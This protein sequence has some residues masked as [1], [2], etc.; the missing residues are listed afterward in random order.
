MKNEDVRMIN[1]VIEPNWLVLVL[2][3]MA[4]G[5]IVEGIIISRLLQQQ[6]FQKKE[7]IED[8]I[9]RF[10]Y[11]W[12]EFVAYVLATS[13]VGIFIASLVNKDNITLADINSWVSIILGFVALIVG[14]ISLY[15]S[16]YNVEQAN[17]SQQEIKKTAEELSVTRG[18][19][20]DINGEWYFG[21]FSGKP[22]R[23]E[24]KKSGDNW[25]Y[26]DSDG[27]VA[28]DTIINDGGD[29]YYVDKNGVMV[30]NTWVVADEKKYYMTGNGKAVL[31]GTKTIDGKEYTFENGYLKE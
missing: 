21:D 3:A 6:K 2:S 22:V 12:G 29:I 27:M 28:K 4:I 7:G 11:F 15:L 19:Q 16:F 20:K 5:I 8:K 14:I 1:I 13:I 9:E 31:S 18:W 10:R 30:M 17:K 26:L 23:N 24:W 25:F